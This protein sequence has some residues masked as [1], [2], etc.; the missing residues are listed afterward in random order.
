MQRFSALLACRKFCLCASFSKWPSNALPCDWKYTYDTVAL[1]YVATDSVKIRRT[2]YLLW[3]AH[4][5]SQALTDVFNN[6]VTVAG[7]LRARALTHP[8]IPSMAFEKLWRLT[9]PSMSMWAPAKKST[10]T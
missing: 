9:R 1:A 4:A 5:V 7:A 10:N 8:S 2:K 3:R 6:A